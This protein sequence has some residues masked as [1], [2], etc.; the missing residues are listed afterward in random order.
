MNHAW[1]MR[2]AIVVALLGAP[3]LAAQQDPM[4]GVITSLPSLPGMI[5]TYYSAGAASRAREVQGILEKGIP[6]FRERLGI[7]LQ[8]SLALLGP[9][10][11]RAINPNYKLPGGAPYSHFLPGVERL[12]GLPPIMFLPAESGHALTEQTRRV[13]EASPELRSLGTADS[14]ADRFAMLIG[15]H[16][17]A[18]VYARADSVVPSEG[19]FN[20]FVATYLAYA[21]LRSESPADARLWQNLSEAFVR[22]LEPKQTALKAMHGGSGGGPDTYVWYQASIQMRV[23]EVYEKQGMDFYAQ[24]RRRRAEIGPAA[25]AVPLIQTLERFS[26]GFIAWERKYH[27]SATPLR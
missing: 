3:R 19:W 15:F 27:A 8:V 18:H 16:E 17:L 2:V 12:P 10:E 14:L 9:A 26:P 1:S 5:P 22:H 23:H 25:G 6:F 4:V 7:G 21:F 20:E 13:W 11:W 24:L